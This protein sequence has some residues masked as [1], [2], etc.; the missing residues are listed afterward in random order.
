MKLLKDLSAGAKSAFNAVENIIGDTSKKLDSAVASFSK[1]AN[2]AASQAQDAFSAFG[3]QASNLAEQ[4]SDGIG[5]Q[6]SSLGEQA[7]QVLDN[8]DS[9]VGQAIDDIASKAKDAI[10]DAATAAGKAGKQLADWGSNAVDRLVASAKTAISNV[11][12]QIKSKI[13]LAKAIVAHQFQAARSRAEGAVA[14]VANILKAVYVNAGWWGGDSTDFVLVSGCYVVQCSWLG[15]GEHRCE[16]KPGDDAE[17][18]QAAQAIM[19]FL[20]GGRGRGGAN[21]TMLGFDEALIPLTDELMV[22][23]GDMHIHIF[24][25]S[26]FDTFT[27]GLGSEKRSLITDLR[28]L[29]EHAAGQGVSVENI[30]QVGDCLDVWVTQIFMDVLC[31]LYVLAAGV[32][33][34]ALARELGPILDKCSAFIKDV[35]RPLTDN[36]DTVGNQ[37]AAIR[38]DFLRRASPKAVA[39]IVIGTDYAKTLPNTPLL[40]NPLDFTDANAVEEAMKE[41]YDDVWDMFTRVPG[42]HDNNVP[43]DYLQQKYGRSSGLNNKNDPYTPLERGRK[44]CIAIEHGEA[45]DRTNR[46][47]VYDRPNRGFM[48]TRYFT[49]KQWYDAAK[50]DWGA[51]LWGGTIGQGAAE[52][53]AGSDDPSLKILQQFARA[54]A[55]DLRTQ[56]ATNLQGH[57]YRLIVLGHSHLEEIS[58]DRL[59]DEVEELAMGGALRA[60]LPG[61]TETVADLLEELPT[62]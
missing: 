5:D 36:I 25:G 23:L 1:S 8:A 60:T 31:D 46:R 29:L 51:L 27:T 20:D 18:Q 45:R 55:Y 11:Q 7:E 50:S 49:V 35:W 24:K 62:I 21:P 39:D 54:R 59:L 58:S 19:R 12:S 15:D 56:N 30:I 14:N 48:L 43:N 53:V 38:A 52:T 2:Q 10:G 9:N 17:D 41:V 26:P 16:L 6:L 22:F 32:T 33:P 44:N 40:T 61:V 47:D 28:E 4:A 37:E 13:S 42:N 57:K 3:E 34:T